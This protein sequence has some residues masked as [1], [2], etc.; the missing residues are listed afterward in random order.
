MKIEPQD[1]IVCYKE[2]WRRNARSLGHID[3]CTCRAAFD[4]KDLGFPSNL[5]WISLF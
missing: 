5:G 1:A 4:E 3:S 2:R